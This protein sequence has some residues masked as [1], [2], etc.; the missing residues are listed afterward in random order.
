MLTAIIA[1]ARKEIALMARDPTALAILFVMP[2]AFILVMSLAMAKVFQPSARPISLALADEDHGAFAAELAREIQD[3][4]G[5]AVITQWQGRPIDHV[6]GERLIVERRQQAL[7]VV[8]A[9]LTEA[10]RGTITG[11]SAGPRDIRLVTD[12]TL[13]P[14]ILAPLRAAIAGL[15]QQ[16]AFRSISGPGID[17]IVAQLRSRGGSVPEDFTRDLKQR[18]NQTQGGVSRIVTVAEGV[19]AGMGATR[20]PNS[21]E[22]MVPGYTL[23]GLFFIAMQL[24]GNLFEEK[25]LGTFRRL[26]VAAVPRWALMAGKLIAFMGINILQVIVMF[27]VGVWAFPLFGVPGMSLGAH[28]EGIV[29]VTLAVSLAANSLG[30][31]LAALARTPAQ[32]TG[33]GLI[34]VLTS[35]MLGGV[36]VPRFVMPQFMQTVGLVSPHTWGLMAY[37]DILIRGANVVTIMP[38]TLI[39]LGFAVVFFAIAAW[40]FR[41]E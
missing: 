29:L 4:G 14:E 31:L 9:G 25:R 18:A 6:V 27:A 40:R 35:A 5:F 33:L 36:M 38:A 32:S 10:M 21:V 22:Q 3:S 37:Q 19:P 15:A 28:P 41:W 30:L 12:P 16:S 39:L 11:Q 7:I 8:P 2:L 1:T 23:F 24:A 13:S 34:V 20:R 26:L 17:Q